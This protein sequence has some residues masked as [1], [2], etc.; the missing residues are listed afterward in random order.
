VGM[1]KDT[2]TIV[3]GTSKITGKIIIPKDN[4]KDSIFV[5]IVVPH[6]ISGEY[7]KYKAL[8]DQSA[9]FSID[10]DVETTISLISLSTSLNPYQIL[11]VKLKSG[12]VT[13]IDI[14][15]NSDD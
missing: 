13:N 10:A 5:I 11:F 1:V 7:V 3:A 15:Y 2:T 14:A 6:P 12:G 9:K 8:V 4:Y